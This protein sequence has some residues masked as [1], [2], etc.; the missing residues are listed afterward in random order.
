MHTRTRDWQ[1]GSGTITLWTILSLVLIVLGTAAF[2][3]LYAATHGGE[4]EFRG[5]TTWPVLALIALILPLLVLHELV[6]GATMRRYGARPSYGAGTFYKVMPYFYC[7]AEGYRFTRRQYAV[8]A[9]APA[10]LISLAGALW[11]AF[12]PY[13]GWLLVPLGFHLGGC[14]GDFWMLGLVLRQPQGTCLE[15]R[16][17]GIRFHDC[18]GKEEYNAH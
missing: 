6:H 8:V 9:L 10:A 16:K 13:G 14:I 1:P 2:T 18:A 5:E 3:A 11:I 12:L 17:T 4:A 15:D 7:T